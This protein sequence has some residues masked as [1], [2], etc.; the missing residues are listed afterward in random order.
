[1]I[2]KDVVKALVEEK[3]RESG[4]ESF[5]VDVMVKPGNLVVVEIDSEVGID[6]DECVAISRFIEAG[7]DREAEDY[8]LEVGSAGVTSPLKVLRQYVKNI[9]NPV[10]VLTRAG[11]K[12]SGVLTDANEAGFTLTVSKQVKPE[13]AKRK[14]TVEENMPFGY[15]EVKYVK[16]KF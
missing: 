5:L 6:I 16:Y 3:L 4:S 15:D 8:E 7:L 12:L 10:E 9:G 11:I 1:M 2:D 14:M 13:G